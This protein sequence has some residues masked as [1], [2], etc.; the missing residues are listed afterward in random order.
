MCAL[1]KCTSTV[2]C[3]WPD[4]GSMSRNMSLLI[5]ITNT[6]CV[7]WLNKLLSIAKHNGMAPIKIYKYCMLTR[8]PYEG[9]FRLWCCEDACKSEPAWTSWALTPIQHTASYKERPV[10]TTRL[11]TGLLKMI[12]GVLTTCHTQYTWDSSI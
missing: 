10:L 8:W 4:D 6:C 12:V 5:L 2:F 3:V 1:T 9:L 7:Y 11:Y